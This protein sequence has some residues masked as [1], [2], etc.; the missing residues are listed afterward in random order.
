MKY[1]SFVS[2]VSFVISVLGILRPF[3]SFVIS[4]LIIKHGFVVFS[5]L[6]IEK[7]MNGLD[8]HRVE[9]KRSLVNSSWPLY[10]MPDSGAAVQ[11]GG[12]GHGGT[13]VM[14]GWWHG[15]DHGGIP[16]T[17]SGSQKDV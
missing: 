16:C 7:R 4:V 12:S 15:A 11:H 17:P 9:T 5:I 6:V 8:G 3:G 1:H 14:G 10:T 13:R 2:F